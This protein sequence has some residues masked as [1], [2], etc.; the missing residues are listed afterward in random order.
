L[1]AQEVVVAAVVVVAIVNGL[2]MVLESHEED[3]VLH[4]RRDIAVFP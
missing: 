3:E 4:Q 2:V 1:S